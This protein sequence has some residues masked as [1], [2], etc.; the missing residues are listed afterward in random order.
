MGTQ[1]SGAAEGRK[2]G[3]P[4][5]QTDGDNNLDNGQQTDGDNDNNLAPADNNGEGDEIDRGYV[6]HIMYYILRITERTMVTAGGARLGQ[7][8]CF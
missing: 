6:L 8:A 1:H 5:Q 3:R 2:G 7:Q 4:G